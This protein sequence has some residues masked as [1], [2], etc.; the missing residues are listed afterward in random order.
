MPDNQSR[1]AASPYGLFTSNGASPYGLS[2]IEKL[3]W[4]SNGVERISQIINS[5]SPKAR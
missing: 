2:I 5:L 1:E 3:H 4:T